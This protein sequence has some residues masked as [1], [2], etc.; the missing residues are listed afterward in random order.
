MTK[1]IGAV[2]LNQPPEKVSVYKGISC[3]LLSFQRKAITASQKYVK[4]LVFSLLTQVSIVR[5]ARLGKKAY[6]PCYYWRLSRFE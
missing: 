2:L 6:K 1:N 4:Q 5:V 3:A